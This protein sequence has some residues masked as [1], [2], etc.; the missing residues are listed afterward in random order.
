M[1]SVFFNLVGMSATVSIVVIVLLLLSSY[2]NSRYTVKWYYYLWLVL[3][4]RLLIPFDFGITS[5]PAEF[6]VHDRELINAETFSQDVPDALPEHAIQMRPKGSERTNT[7]EVVPMRKSLP[8]TMGK[9][10]S[11]GDRGGRLTLG[12]LA[13]GIYLAGMIAFLIWQLALYLTFQRSVNRW[14]YESS[15][16]QIKTTFDQLR[17]DMGIRS[18]LQI[19]ICKFIMSPMI[20]GTLKPR[21]LLPH[22]KYAEPDLEMILKHE[23]VHYKRNDLWYKQ[24]LLAVRAIHWFNPLIH[25]MTAEANKTIEI[26][27]DEEV[28]Q[29][30]DLELRKRYCERVLDMMQ[31]M[32][33]PILPLSTGFYGSKSMMKRRLRFILDDAV[34]KKGVLA[35]CIFVAMI[36]TFSACKFEISDTELLV[37]IKKAAVDAYGYDE[38]GRRLSEMQDCSVAL[39]YDFDGNDEDETFFSLNISDQ[40]HSS[41]LKYTGESDK[42]AQISVFKEA[43]PGI[44]YGIEAAKLEG[45][46]SVAILLTIDYQGMPFGSGYW[47]LYS[48]KNGKFEQIDL[49][50]LEEKLKVRILTAEEVKKNVMNAE[51]AVYLQG[52]G[53]DDEDGNLKDSYVAGIYFSD[54]IDS[55]TSRLKTIYY[56]PMSEYDVEGFQTWGNDAAG[57]AL[58]GMNFTDAALVKGTEE[59]GSAFLQ[60]DEIVYITLPNITAEVK[61][62]YEYRNGSWHAVKG[63]VE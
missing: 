11:G 18:N 10:S 59:T 38:A 62:D 21:L 14:S 41:V 34:K 19:L 31:G 12:S 17:S 13:F 25:L 3:A 8:D 47:E 29:G 22:E 35:F 46:S 32:K 9:E 54:D 60:T 63:T 28:L 45:T 27:C 6:M 5:P 15:S 49:K 58:T 53:E 39:S 24:L 30:V 23:L 55:D 4:F 51:S 50:P 37:P 40:G 2:L 43:D 44:S 36:L 16:E 56:A 1:Q 20:V 52:D 48:W 57:K 42:A 26:S 33:H 61:R 7:A